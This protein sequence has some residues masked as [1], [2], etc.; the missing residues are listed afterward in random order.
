MANAKSK[1]M[2]TVRE[3]INNQGWL[4]AQKL[5]S[6]LNSQRIMPHQ[7]RQKR[8]HCGKRHKPDQIR[9]SLASPM[10]GLAIEN[11]ERTGTDQQHRPEHFRNFA[12]KPDS[13][14]EMKPPDDGQTA[15]RQRQHCPNHYTYT[16]VERAT[17]IAEHDVKHA[18]QELTD[19][20]P[21]HLAYRQKKHIGRDV[22]RTHGPTQGADQAD[23]QEDVV[24][25]P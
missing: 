14:S 10:N 17:E 23:Q 11:A 8:S 24:D 16:A 5:F 6:D 25:W 1:A 2:S 4:V 9:D 19:G 3:T 20:D 21:A 12:A 7:C 13:V 22:Q 18:K 15:Q